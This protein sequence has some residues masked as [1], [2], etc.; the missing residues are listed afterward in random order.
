MVIMILIYLQVLRALTYSTTGKFQPP[1]GKAGSFS[2]ENWGDYE[3]QDKKG[4]RKL[5]RRSTVY[6]KRVDSMTDEHWKAVMDGVAEFIGRRKA[7][8]KSEESI[9]SVDDGDDD[10]EDVLFDPMFE[11]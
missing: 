2:Q 11:S 7:P 6:Q 1:S 3:I 10:D 5:K 9:A 4:K 8:V